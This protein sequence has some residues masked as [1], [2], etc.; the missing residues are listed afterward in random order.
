VVPSG[1]TVVTGDYPVSYL[2]SIFLNLTYSRIYWEIRTQENHAL[3]NKMKTKFII[4]T[5]LYL[6]FYFKKEKL[7]NLILY[8]IFPILISNSISIF[9]SPFILINYVQASL[10]IIINTRV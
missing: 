5:K 1:T 3:K 10:C 9:S 2:W 6:L 7:K 4:C 8:I